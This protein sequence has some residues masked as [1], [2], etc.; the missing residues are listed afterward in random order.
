MEPGYG[1]VLSQICLDL[2]N[3]TD[4][5]ALVGWSQARAADRR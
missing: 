5:A 1:D 3:V 2:S 4:L